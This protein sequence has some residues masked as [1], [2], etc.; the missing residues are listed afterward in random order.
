MDNNDDNGT[1]SD[2]LP[3]EYNLESQVCNKELREDIKK[4]L[5]TLSSLELNLITFLYLSDH[6]PYICKFIE[7][8]NLSYYEVNRIKKM[9]L[10]K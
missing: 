2:N 3:S 4:A 1:F 10:R 7:E 5:A 8:H 9:P 6:R